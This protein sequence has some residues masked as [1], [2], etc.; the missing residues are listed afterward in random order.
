M[1]C[2]LWLTLHS[3]LQS[4]SSHWTRVTNCTTPQ[5]L[6]DV[7]GCAIESKLLWGPGSL[8]EGGEPGP[9]LDPLGVQ[10]V[11]SNLVF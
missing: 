2:H 8:M 10:K 5:L 3:G 6:T 4:S 11:S 9:R 7:S 1:E